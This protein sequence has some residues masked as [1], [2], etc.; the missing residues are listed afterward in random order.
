LLIVLALL[1]VPVLL[2]TG[3]SD[4]E[5]LQQKDATIASL[6]DEVD[7]LQTDLDDERSQ[8]QQLQADLDRALSDIRTKEHVW[9]QEKEGLTQITL[10][11]EVTFTSGSTRLTSQGKE[12]LDRIWNVLE[13]Y[14]ERTVFIEGHT[15]NVP[16]SPQ[17]QHRFRSNWELSSAR[18]NAVLHY[19]RDK[20]GLDPQRIGA[21]GYGEHRP[22]ASNDAADGRS[23][24]RR[25]VITVG[26]SS[27]T[28]NA[29]P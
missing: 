1:V 17:W 10:D 7:R 16:I 26:S 29:Y 27:G 15:D 28:T 24:N 12:I 5:A 9:M 14:P 25:V 2:L 8:T 18:A 11:G 22:I 13:N 6:Q 21:V 4:K 20:Y 23:M 3:C 19:V